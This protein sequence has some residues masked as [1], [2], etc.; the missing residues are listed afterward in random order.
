M[1][2]AMRAHTKQRLAER[3]GLDATSA[4][5]FQMAK[6]IAHG[7]A[8]LLSRQSKTVALWQLDHQ[9]QTLRLVFDSR[10]RGILTAL[11]REDSTDY[12]AGKRL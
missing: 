3:Y 10:I 9:G 2:P 5:L 8:R 12:L 4:D 1:T 7:E 11:P 6:R